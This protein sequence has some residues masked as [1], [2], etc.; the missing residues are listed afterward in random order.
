MARMGEHITDLNRVG[1]HVA[2]DFVNTADRDAGVVIIDWLHSYADLLA[3][4]HTG[5]LLSDALLM[6]LQQHSA[7]APDEAVA[8]YTQ[9]H[10]LREAL[11][12]VGSAIAGG[13]AIPPDALALIND[14]L[15]ESAAQRQLVAEGGVVRWGWLHGDAQLRYPLWVIVQSATEVLT[16]QVGLLRECA[17]DECGW[18]FLDTS[19]N[20]SRR[21]CDMRDCGNREK[22]RRHYRRMTGS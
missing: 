20:H 16:M 2:L 10:A 21:W 17:G 8:A 11:Y 6:Q 19:R 18:L 4:A 5:G 3:W 13:R 1:G 9:A 22:A 7:A 15:V 14:L 12:A